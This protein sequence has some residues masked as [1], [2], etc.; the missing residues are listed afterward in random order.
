MSEAVEELQ[1]RCSLKIALDILH[2]TD[3]DSQIPPAEGPNPQFSGQESAPPTSPRGFFLRSRFKKSQPEAAKRKKNTQN[4]CGLKGE[5]KTRSQGGF[6]ALRGSGKAPGGGTN[7]SRAPGGGTN[8]ARTR[9]GGTNPARG[10]ARDSCVPP[11]PDSHNCRKTGPKSSP[12]QRKMQPKMGNGVSWKK[13]KGGRS[14]QGRKRGC[15]GGDSPRDQAQGA[16]EEGSPP[17]SGPVE[18]SR[19]AGTQPGRAFLDSSCETASDELEKSISSESESLA[20]QLDGGREAEGGKHPDGAGVASG[21]DR[22]GR[23]QPGS[24]PGPSGAF[25][26]PREEEQQEPS[27]PAGSKGPDSEEDEGGQISWGN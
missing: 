2:Q 24:S 14:Q 13:A 15:G 3:S 22:R 7:L 20:K 21:A 27:R 6:V 12:R 8:P 5:P 26:Q 17:K 18:P 10:R 19:K 1:Y 11:A 23:S 25:P 9:G 4:N 16:P